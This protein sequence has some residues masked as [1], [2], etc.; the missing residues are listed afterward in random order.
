MVEGAPLL[1]EY[2]V[3][4]SIEGSNPSLSASFTL[5]ARLTE[6]GSNPRHRVCRVRRNRRERFRTAAGWPRA[7]RGAR[8]RKRRAIPLSPPVSPWVHAFPRGVRTLDIGYAGFDGIAGSV[9]GQPQAGPERSVGTRPTSRLPAS[10]C[11]ACRPKSIRRHDRGSG[12]RQEHEPVGHGSA[13]RGGKSLTH[14]ASLWRGLR[15]R[16]IRRPVEIA[17]IACG[18][19][20]SPLFAAAARGS[21]RHRPVSMP[22]AHPPPGWRRARG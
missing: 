11:C 16:G 1:R 2:R 4:S 12:P 14:D 15:A 17:C 10:S 5:G 13:A 9:S 3:K 18:F 21:A 7:Q 22:C 8:R 20:L 19:S 6:R